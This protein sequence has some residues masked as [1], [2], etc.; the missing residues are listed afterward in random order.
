MNELIVMEKWLIFRKFAAQIA[1]TQNQQSCLVVLLLCFAFC[2]IEIAI[3]N[4]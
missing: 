3:F 4:P 2:P 1:P